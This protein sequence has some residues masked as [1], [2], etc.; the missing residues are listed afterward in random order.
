MDNLIS[1]FKLNNTSITVL[2][3]AVLF[4][5]FVNVACIIGLRAKNDKYTGA[6]YCML[7]FFFC[8]IFI[9]VILMGNVLLAF[10]PLIPAVIILTYWIIFSNSQ[11][12]K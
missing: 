7:T 12:Q 3:A 11:K 2:S 9:M 5:I 4:T 1:G 8:S 10:A 6:I